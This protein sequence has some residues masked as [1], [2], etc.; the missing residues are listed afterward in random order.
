MTQTNCCPNCGAEVPANDTAG[1]CL[2][3]RTIAALH[4]E[5][6]PT[7][8][9][10]T[11]P[12]AGAGQHTA[13]T[14]RTPKDPFGRAGVTSEYL[15]DSAHTGTED[16][17]THRLPHGAVVR[18]F[19]DYE[20]LKELGRGGM[21][22]VYE[23]RQ[24][25]LNR[26][27]ALKMIKAG[28]LA[29]SDVLRRFQNEAEAVALLDH[30]GIVPVYEIG[31]YEGQK[32]FSMKLVSGGSLVGL[33]SKYVDD[34]K[35]AARLT[36]QACEAVHHAHMRGIL[37]RDL[38]PAN[39]LIDDASQVHVTDFGLAKWVENDSEMTQTGAILGTPA[40]MSPEQASGHRAAVTTASDV[41]GLGAVLYALL[42]GRAPFAG[43]SVVDTLE[44]VRKEPPAPPSKINR[45]VPRDLETICLKCLEKEPRRRY[46][47]A[48]AL[49]EELKSWLD[50]RP[51]S[52]RRVNTLER[53]WLWCKRRPAIAAMSAAVLLAIF[54]GAIVSTALWLRAERNFR[55]E[56]AALH[57]ANQRF[58]LAMEAIA[59]FHTGVSEEALLTRPELKDLRNRLLLAASEFYG[60]LGVL[61]EGRSDLASRR[62]LLDANDRVAWLTDSIGSNQDALAMHQR[63]LK[64]REALASAHRSDARARV[65]VA[66]SLLAVGH[67]LEKIGKT[68]DA[69]RAYERAR[70]ATAQQ[71]GDAETAKPAR[72]ALASAEYRVGWLLDRIGKPDEGLA[73]LTRARDLQAALV[74][75]DPMNRELER[76][77][78][79]ILSSM[80]T[81]F[82]ETGKPAKAL[83]AHEESRTIRQKLAHANPS[84]NAFQRDLATSHE[85]EGL[86]LK[87][88]GRL[89]EATRAYEA[90][91]T[92]RQ[93][94]ADANPAVSQFQEALASN[95]DD[96]GMLLVDGGKPADAMQAYE[97]ALAIYQKL[98][99]AN[100]AVTH[101]QKRIAYM[102][103][104][105]GTLLVRT[106]KPIEG[107]RSHER[108]LAIRRRL[109][110]ANPTV[111]EFQLDLAVCHIC[112]GIQFAND[113][114]PVE[115]V[116][117][118]KS[119][120]AILERLANSSPGVTEFQKNL[121][122]CYNNIAWQTEVL[123]KRSEA[124]ASFEAA[125]EIFQRLTD[126]N[127]DVV[128]FQN[129]LAL[130]HCN[131]GS[132]QAHTGRLAEALIS[133]EASRAILQRLVDTN[134]AAR[135]FEMILGGVH[136]LIGE[137]RAQTGKASLAL[138]AC[139]TSRAI[140][141]K[142]VAI[143]PGN[144][145]FQS[146]L[147]KTHQ[148]IGRLLTWARK[149][150]E[151]LAAYD[152]ARQ[153]FERLLDVQ[154]RV[155][156][157]GAGLA[158]ALTGAA[159]VLRLEHRLDEGRALCVRATAAW[160]K[161]I[162][163]APE[164]AE[165][166]SGP[167]EAQLRLGQIERSSGDVAAA[168]A[169]MRRA[170]EICKPIPAGDLTSDTIAAC[171]HASSAALAG[172]AG[173]AISPA[174]GEVETTR[175]M[176]IL[177]GAMA[178]GLRHVDWWM[179]EAALGPLRNRPDW[180]LLKMDLAM[181]ED[182]FVR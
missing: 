131:I 22:V 48:A 61:L 40:Y 90:A 153:V 74:L 103:N 137:I 180:K 177:A 62:A 176:T 15:A 46:A 35:S 68:G 98:A 45:R 95:H 36:A 63:V 31:E 170:I 174:Q 57:D 69:L 166:K 115:A 152:L 133:F 105:I 102:Q 49:A 136:R 11:C 3:C 85:G 118:F 39:I 173:S 34:P 147:G 92:I 168:S 38:K 23:A 172:L 28:Q 139:E 154:P 161:A 130:D 106:G 167:A 32:Y 64:D 169:A 179:S 86:L 107:L 175:A 5:S 78:A 111:T 150:A 27:V 181:P 9:Q 73:A 53:G 1:L 81:L 108:S 80:S 88:A 140:L 59:T 134:R 71:S 47:S 125:R 16:G 41:Y 101:F 18:Y 44:A 42:T 60:R 110:D 138:A 70:S 145:E 155:A 120:L 126:A 178:R 96:F 14:D 162:K 50:S 55:N 83:G 75:A 113:A 143:E 20:I 163:A 93:K 8:D 122:V 148:L 171:C 52:A 6:P 144:T 77:H 135:E 128:E 100:P 141:Q 160:E 25:S 54:V 132:V 123:G 56:Q 19:G 51:I 119:A 94:L 116:S 104:N 182:P 124:L 37:H 13:G 66:R 12:G 84:I 67:L 21:G 33:I 121:A 72:V 164:V 117:A 151:A 58:E 24:I 156:A 112:I 10:L 82:E 30:P 97:A 29:D 4:I 89:P 157:H 149:P 127:P 65:D 109:A 2:R 146:E 158:N 76:Q 99:D 17:A 79:E 43:D 159:E 165:F 91:R 7:I 114:Q 129:Y 87:R 26:A 142:I